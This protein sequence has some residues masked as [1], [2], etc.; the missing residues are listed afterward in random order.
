MARIIVD[1]PDSMIKAM[2]DNGKGAID[3]LK[4]ELYQRLIYQSD[5][6]P[7][8]ATNGDVIKAL[9]LHKDME[10]DEHKNY[11]QMYYTD[12]YITFPSSW[13]NAPYKAGDKDVV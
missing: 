7:D 9:F 13:W 5:I 4:T 6:L 12:S 2:R 1:I 8:N 11:T 10:I 3:V